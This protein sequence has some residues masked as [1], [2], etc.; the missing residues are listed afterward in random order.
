MRLEFRWTMYISDKKK[1]YILNY[2]ELKSVWFQQFNWT[3]AD[4]NLNRIIS[5][6]QFQINIE[7]EE[8]LAHNIDYRN[9]F[10]RFG[11]AKL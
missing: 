5:I 6:G 9:A 4:G 2:D 11:Q 8:N 1:L 7:N 3:N 10:N